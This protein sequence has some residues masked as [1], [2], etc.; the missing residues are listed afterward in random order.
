M[1]A[2]ARV[3]STMPCA[4]TAVSLWLVAQR[5]AHACLKYTAGAGLPRGL[6]QLQVCQQ[7][8]VHWSWL[9]F[10]AQHLWA[11]PFALPIIL[12]ASP[13]SHPVDITV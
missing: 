10:L 6:V 1:T 5:N 9:A 8:D 7:L 13:Q 4:S 3:A 2:P 11:T 12:E